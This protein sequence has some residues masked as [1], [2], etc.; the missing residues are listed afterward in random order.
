ML[1]KASRQVFNVEN[2]K[3]K[4]EL[5]NS[6]NEERVKSEINR[7]KEVFRD[8][9]EIY[10]MCNDFDKINSGNYSAKMNFEAKNHAVKYPH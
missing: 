4:Y 5:P 8:N 6:F 1:L 9:H 10:G 7:Y 2:T 3:S